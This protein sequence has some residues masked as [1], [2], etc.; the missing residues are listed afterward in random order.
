MNYSEIIAKE[1]KVETNNTRRIL[2]AFKDENLGWRP[3]EKSMTVGE[4]ASH[5]VE[6]HNWVALALK[7]ERFDFQTDYH[8]HIATSVNELIEL[9][10]KNLEANLAT[11]QSFT[12]EDW[13]QK[14]ILCSGDYVI[15]ESN[16]QIASRFIIQNHLI[17]HRGQLSVYLR[18]LD[19]P[20]PGIYGPSADE[21]Q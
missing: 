6:L 1:F 12:D 2:A 15:H 8:R 14:W 9:L 19:L 3:H 21:K 5:V 4:L 18:L 7:K 16:K 20:V 11:L 17:H 13:Q 10:D